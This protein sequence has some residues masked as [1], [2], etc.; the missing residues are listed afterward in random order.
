MKGRTFSNRLVRVS[1]LLPDQLNGYL[2]SKLLSSKGC[3]IVDYSKDD[4]SAIIP[5]EDCYDRGESQSGYQTQLDFDLE[6]YDEIC[7]SAR[8][9]GKAR[10]EI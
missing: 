3:D 5:F 2:Q 7:R 6:A 8:G 4:R 1:D 10:G 9:S